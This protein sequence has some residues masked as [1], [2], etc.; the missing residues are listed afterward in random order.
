MDHIRTYVR[1]HAFAPLCA[2]QSCVYVYVCMC[3]Y[4]C[5]ASK[6]WGASNAAAMA[7]LLPLLLLLLLLLFLLLLFLLLFFLV[8]P[9]GVL[10]PLLLLLLLLLFLSRLST[11][12][13]FLP[14]T[15]FFLSLPTPALPYLPSILSRSL[16]PTLLPPLGG[17]ALLLSSP[18]PPSTSSPRPISE[19]GPGEGA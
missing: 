17:G 11:S 10:L 2:I 18:L 15:G 1:M 19:G 13:S 16:L 3:V 6:P 5:L 12:P 14:I 8:L 7:F 4:M 9:P